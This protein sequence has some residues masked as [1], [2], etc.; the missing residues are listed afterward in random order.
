MLLGAPPECS[1]RALRDRKPV[2]PSQIGSWTAAQEQTR[3]QR[4][5]G[6][7]EEDT[8][9]WPAYRRSVRET[10]RP[11]PAGAALSPR[12]EWPY[13]ALAGPGSASTC[14][15]GRPSTAPRPSLGSLPHTRLLPRSRGGRAL[16]PAPRSDALFA[17]KHGLPLVTCTPGL[18]PQINVGHTKWRAQRKHW[19]ELRSPQRLPGPTSLM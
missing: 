18:R 5:T 10:T 9:Y 19:Q 16:T 8:G 1:H 6:V 11:L 4:E 14:P 7:T 2:L 17:P 3:L 12:Q 15:P 13:W